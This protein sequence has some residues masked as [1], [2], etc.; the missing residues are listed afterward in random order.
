MLAALCVIAFGVGLCM[1][2]FAVPTMVDVGVAVILV[3]FV[4]VA[5]RIGDFVRWLTR[6]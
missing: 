6:E 3:G 1:I 2:G 5:V 4:G